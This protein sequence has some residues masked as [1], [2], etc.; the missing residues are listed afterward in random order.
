MFFQI[1]QRLTETITT[2]N[3]H[4]L[5]FQQLAI[6]KQNTRLVIDDQYPVTV[7]AMLGSRYVKFECD[8]RE[9]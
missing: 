6:G 2:I 4:P 7:T 5:L 3:D 8:M 9:D 1:L